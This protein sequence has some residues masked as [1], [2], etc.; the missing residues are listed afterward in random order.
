MSILAFTLLLATQ[1]GEIGIDG[2]GYF[3]LM[4]EGRVVYARSGILTSNGGRLALRGLPFVPTV[5]CRNAESVQ[6]KP[7]GIVV[8]GGS[9]IG[10][11]Y[12]ALFPNEKLEGQGDTYVASG[13]GLIRKPGDDDAGLVTGSSLK[14]GGAAQ[15]RIESSTSRAIEITLKAEAQVGSDQITLGDLAELSSA[16]VA[17]GLDK[18]SIA[19]APTLGKTR[20]ID[21]DQIITKLRAAKVDIQST[22]LRGTGPITVSNPGQNVAHQQ[23]IDEAVRAASE[24]LGAKFNVAASETV[25]P[26]VVPSGTVTLQAEDLDLEGK[27][28]AI[29]VAVF[30]NGHR[31]NS[32]TIALNIQAPQRAFEANALVKVVFRKNDLR[33]EASGRVKKAAYIGEAVEVTVKLDPKSTETVHLGTAIAPNLVEVQ[34]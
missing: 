15:M 7:D 34:L 4:D 21:R 18:L 30:V 11:V 27:A 9:E 6:I 14:S 24:K 25:A 23:F 16:A 13:R 2:K 22:I 5:S 31:F 17:A 26:M 28:P 3:R 12:L 8:S 20:T 33:V 29:K 10:Q 1:K 19:T 32:R